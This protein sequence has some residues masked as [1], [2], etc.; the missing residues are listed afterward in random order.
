MAGSASSITAEA[1]S[2]TAD[3]SSAPSATRTTTAR[4]DNVPKSIPTAQ[5]PP[6]GVERASRVRV[7]VGVIGRI[8][9]GVERAPGS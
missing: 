1:Y 4:P 5:A 3:P 9:M 8:V 7:E 2:C 6:G